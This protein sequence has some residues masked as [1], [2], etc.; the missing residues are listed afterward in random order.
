MTTII[1]HPTS[2]KHIIIKSPTAEMLEVARRDNASGNARIEKSG[3]IT[4]HINTKW[5]YESL[6][7]SD[8]AKAALAAEHDDLCGCAECIAKTDAAIAFFHSER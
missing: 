7:A 4:A 2:S 6:I 8:A 1:N 5:Q 3:N